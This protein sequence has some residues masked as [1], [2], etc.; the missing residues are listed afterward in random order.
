MGK[1]VLK[2]RTIMWIGVGL[3]TIV[4][5]YPPW[6]FSQEVPMLVENLDPKTGELM[7]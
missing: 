2:G 3:S 1:P 5:L 7:A 4:L 6:Q